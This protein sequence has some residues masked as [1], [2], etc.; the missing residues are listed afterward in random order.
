M[1]QTSYFK[2]KRSVTGANVCD[3]QRSSFEAEAKLMPVK[4][5]FELCRLAKVIHGQAFFIYFKMFVYYTTF[6]QKKPVSTPVVSSKQVKMLLQL[7]S[8]RLSRGENFF[9]AAPGPLVVQFIT[10]FYIQHFPIQTYF[11]Q[12][13]FFQV[14]LIKN[15]TNL[16]EP[17]VSSRRNATQGR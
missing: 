2:Q 9:V 17:Y 14:F 16:P 3:T 1:G 8:P 13:R 5:A 6:L 7:G 12:I 10:N 15:I 11:S 4:L